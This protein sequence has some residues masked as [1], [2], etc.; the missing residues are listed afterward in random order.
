MPVYDDLDPRVRAALKETYC[1]PSDHLQL[2]LMDPEDAIRL[3]QQWHRE[4]RASC[5]YA[6]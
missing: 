5:K 1:D 6:Y 4:D 3:I 2:A